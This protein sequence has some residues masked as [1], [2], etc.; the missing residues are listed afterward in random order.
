MRLLRAGQR[1]VRPLNCGVRRRS[2]IMLPFTLEK[3]L[4]LEDRAVLLPW[5]TPWQRLS[6]LGSPS[7]AESSGQL[8]FGWRRPRFLGGL[9]G[10]VS[11]R[12]TRQRPLRDLELHASGEAET[13]QQSFARVSAHLHSLFGEPSRSETSSPEGYPS[14]EWRLPPISIWHMVA[15][16]FGE[17]HVLHIR[18]RGRIEGGLHAV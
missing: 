3:G 14:E 11:A 13:A 5:G 8:L 17:Y 9:C 16:R 2:R 15:E 4:L 12:L 6:E 18:H 7:V 1:S 10:T